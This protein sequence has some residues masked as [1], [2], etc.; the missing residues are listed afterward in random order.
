[1][2]WNKRKELNEL[3]L[4]VE[5][6]EQRVEEL[7]E[8]LCWI[9]GLPGPA[10]ASELPEFVSIEYDRGVN[11]AEVGDCFVVSWQG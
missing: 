6:L 11:I 7:S 2:F 3:R 9:P 4:K 8:R 10:S 1:M 5:K